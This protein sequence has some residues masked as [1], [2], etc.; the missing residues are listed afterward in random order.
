MAVSNEKTINELEVHRYTRGLVGPEIAPAG[1]V[2]DGGRVIGVA[3]PGCWGPMITPTFRGGHE[4]TAPVF[5]EGA[6]VGDSIAIF[7]EEAVISAHASASGTMRINP[8]AYGDDPFVDKKCPGCGQLWP[9]FVVEGTGE[10]AV[11]CAH[12]G[13]V[14]DTFGFDEG[15]TMVFDEQRRVGLTVTA[16][17][18]ERLAERAR[19]VMALPET[20]EQNP[21]LL[22]RPATLAGTLARLRASIGNIGTTP[23][24]MLPDSHNAGDFGASLI[25]AKHPYALSKEALDA[26]KTDGH[27]D[28]ADVRPGAVLIAPVKVAGGGVYFGDAHAAIGEGELALHGVDVTAKVCLRLHVLKGL[29]LEGPLLLPVPEDLPFLAR[30]FDT[31]ELSIGDA[32]AKTYGVS[33]ASHVGPVQIIGTGETLNEATDV[34]ISRAAH[35]FGM[36]TSEVRNRCTINGGVKIARL[37]GAVQLSMLVPFPILDRLSIGDLVRA[38]YGLT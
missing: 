19:E 32:L 30:P 23:S 16:E 27:L 10:Q 2:S 11:R 20:S 8:V 33:V 26:A 28:S 1:R 24:R 22:Y 36:S 25:G 21:I 6:E 4:V 29:T 38:Q 35:L 13:A 9:D 5:V 3:P 34:A 12:C 31:E 7:I 14:I 17:V 15:Y 18:A 37:P